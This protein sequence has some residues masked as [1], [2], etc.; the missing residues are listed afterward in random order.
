[1]TGKPKIIAIVGPTSGG[2]T[3]VAIEI[4]RKIGGET[5]S[6]DSRQIYRGLNIGAGKVTKSEMRGVPHHL[7][8]IAS[9]KRTVSV[10]QYQKSAI[11]ALRD[12]L[13]RG[14]TPILCGGTGQ[15]TDAILFNQSF[16]SVPPNPALRKSLANLSVLKLFEKLKKLDPVRAATIDAKN[17]HRL[18]RAIEIATALGKVPALVPKEAP[19]DTLIIGL[20]LPREELQ[21]RVHTRLIVRLRKGMIAEVKRL[22]ADGLS[23]KRMEELGLD[24]RYLARYLQGKITKQEMTHAIEKESWLYAKRQMVWFKR[25]KDIHWFRYDELRKILPLAQNFI[26]K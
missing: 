23:W 6:T 21:A 4:A 20:N 12:I 11:R 10:A 2:K 9:P 15:Y 19:Y 17:P 3:G 26:N 18:I 16:P 25:N 1:M 22:H 14:K 5:I 8:D 24:Y 13:R 7:L